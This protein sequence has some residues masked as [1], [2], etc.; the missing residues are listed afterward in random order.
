[1]GLDTLEGASLLA[2]GLI[3]EDDTHLGRVVCHEELNERNL[4]QAVQSWDMHSIS[5]GI[6]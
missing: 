4:E 1:M 2:A 3:L 6:Q 5:A